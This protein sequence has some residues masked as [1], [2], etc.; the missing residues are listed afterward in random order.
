MKKKKYIK[1][2]RIYLTFQQCSSKKFEFKFL[3]GET[4]AAEELDSNNL[5]EQEEHQEEHMVRNIFYFNS[6]L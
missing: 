3:G 4:E 2:G 5:E 6:F 1:F